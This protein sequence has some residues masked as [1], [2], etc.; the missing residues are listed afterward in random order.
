MLSKLVTKS[1]LQYDQASCRYRMHGLLRQYGAER[2]AQDPVNEANAREQHSRHFC[3]WLQEQEASLKGA[4]QQATLHEIET[5]IDNVRTACNWAA[6]QGHVARLS[7][8]LG[9]LV[10]FYDWRR[11]YQAGIIVLGNLA[12]RL[13]AACDPSSP[14]SNIVHVALARILVWQSKFTANQGNSEVAGQ[15]AQASL[16]HLDSPSLAGHDTRLVRARIWAQ[17]AYPLYGKD[18]GAA[19]ELF[20]RSRELYQDAGDRA[21]LAYTLLALGRIARNLHDYEEAKEVISQGLAL[22]Q[23]IGDRIG[24]AEALTLLCEIAVCQGQLDRAGALVRQSLAIRRDALGLNTLAYTLI[25]SGRFAEAEAPASESLALFR[26]QGM[27]PM[28][29]WAVLGHAQIRLHLGD[30]GSA[31]IWAKEALSL[32]R[33]VDSKRNTGLALEQL[34]AVAL[35]EGDFVR[36]RDRSRESL[37]VHPEETGN[38]SARSCLG[39]AARRLLRHNEARQ[40]LL[41]GLQWAVK[42]LNFVTVVS[43]LSGTALLLA[44]YGLAERAVE[45]HALVARYPLVA[46]SRW[47]EEVAGR[48]MAAVAAQLPPDAAGAARTRGQAADLWQ[49]AAK[50]LETLANT[51]VPDRPSASVPATQATH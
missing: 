16:A 17:L 24:S 42:N 40:Q 20:T 51:S 10:R 13:A 8:A 38:L 45:V 37:A 28:A 46:N 34:G 11:G 9:A 3:R 49:A 18:P 7:E 22:R 27:L 15:L 1:F 29:F 39:L 43:A 6:S 41:A 19:R 36:S 30:Y 26:D 47:F 2:L 21:G 25:C 48:E 33:Q 14:A 31:R 12:D 23:A 5:E 4:K 32:A 44:D 50:W 35:A